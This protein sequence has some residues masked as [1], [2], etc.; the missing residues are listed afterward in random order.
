MVT[1]YRHDGMSRWDN[2]SKLG[3]LLVQYRIKNGNLTNEDF[4]KGARIERTSF[5][6]IIH[7]E[8]GLYNLDTWVMITKVLIAG[9]NGRRAIASEIQLNKFFYDVMHLPY[10]PLNSERVEYIRE[11][12]RELGIPY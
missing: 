3:Q 6:K 11:Q 9:K 4:A 7:G 10:S 12:L 2:L 8:R 5:S 1:A